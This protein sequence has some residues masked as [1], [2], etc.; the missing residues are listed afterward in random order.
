MIWGALGLVATPAWA[1][2]YRWTDD[3]G[4]VHYTQGLDSVPDRFRPKAQMMV[5]PERPAA[6]VASSLPGDAAGGSTRIPFTPGRPIMVSAKVN[7]GSAANLILDTGA[8]VTVINPR[9]LAGMG[10]GSTQ[11]V[12]G[13][14]K[15]ATGS[16]DVLFV[17]IQSIE[18]GSSRSGPL[19]IAAHDVDLSQGDGLLGRDFL[20]Q[21]K[22]TIDSTA[23]IVTIA[24]K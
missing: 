15:G 12:R 21:F 3:Q 14:V 4:S 1:E 9:V 20:D 23:G 24:P 19:R 18:V 7:G 11:A 2:M 13:S 6:P 10:I 17:P 22:V 16:A 5:F 8:S